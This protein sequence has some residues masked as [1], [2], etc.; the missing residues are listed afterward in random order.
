MNP[1]VRRGARKVLSPLNRLLDL[2]LG[3]INQRVDGVHGALTAWAARTGETEELLGRN[4]SEMAALLD[5]V[6]A[7]TEALRNAQTDTTAHVQA[8]RDELGWLTADVR[9]SL[10]GISAEYADG[11]A[12]GIE[13]LL[14]IEGLSGHY[15]Y[16]TALGDFYV[17]N[18]SPALA[19]GCYQQALELVELEAE[20][21]VLL[22]KLASCER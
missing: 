10:A 7:D 18:N 12:A 13:A 3:E 19:L 22:G 16:H 8:L 5:Q 17:K 2:R 1:S 21:Q 20:R 4:L 15:L 14:N 11:P 9:S 6:V